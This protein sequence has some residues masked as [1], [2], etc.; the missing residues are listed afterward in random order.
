MGKILSLRLAQIVNIFN[1]VTFS[2]LISVSLKSTRHCDYRRQMLF[3]CITEPLNSVWGLVF[4]AG[5]QN[6]EIC[7]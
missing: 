2:S 6:S 1:C 3:N 5:L 7:S 4:T